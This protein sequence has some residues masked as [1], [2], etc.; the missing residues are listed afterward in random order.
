MLDSTA[1]IDKQPSRACAKSGNTRQI[2]DMPNTLDSGNASTCCFFTRKRQCARGF[3][4]LP[5]TSDW[6]IRKCGKNPRSADQTP[7]LDFLDQH[8]KHE[9]RLSAVPADQAGRT[10]ARPHHNDYFKG[11]LGVRQSD[12]T[13]L[14]ETDIRQRCEV[15]R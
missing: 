14:S 7:V 6:S 12:I 3:W 10:V 5:H 4:N 8:L 2:P 13:N 15:D 1:S 9:N 11:E